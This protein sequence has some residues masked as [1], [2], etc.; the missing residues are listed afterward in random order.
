MTAISLTSLQQSRDIAL[1]QL[2]VGLDRIAFSSHGPAIAP[3][4]P[5]LVNGPLV[6]GPMGN[7]VDAYHNFVAVSDVAAQSTPPP[8]IVT[9]WGDTQVTSNTRR[10]EGKPLELC[11][12][13]PSVDFCGTPNLS[14]QLAFR[15]QTHRPTTVGHALTIAFQSDGQQFAVEQ[16]VSIVGKHP[17]ANQTNGIAVAVGPRF[18]RNVVA[19]EQLS[20]DKGRVWNRTAALLDEK[21]RTKSMRQM[22]FELA[23]AIAE[24]QTS[25]AH[26]GEWALETR[27]SARELITATRSTGALD[28]DSLERRIVQEHAAQQE[29]AIR[30]AHTRYGY[31]PLGPT[32]M[33]PRL[34]VRYFPLPMQRSG[35]SERVDR[36][37][38]GDD[39]F[40]EI[41]ETTTFNA[42][43]ATPFC[44]VIADLLQAAAIL[45]GPAFPYHEATA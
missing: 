14:A 25:W 10:F 38:G 19:M 42:S 7:Q 34:S 31:D 41:T 2:G 44:S 40:I 5:G 11:A 17:A 39:P 32:G 1:H 33:Y 28:L 29:C 8:S 6:S 43:G 35:L 45:F 16:M 20:L 12:T 30:T 9:R 3:G 21:S 18:L 15:L 23:S 24:E 22:A 36:A 27:K 26:S 13:V 4:M 37:T